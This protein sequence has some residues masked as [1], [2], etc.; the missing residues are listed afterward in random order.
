MGKL[1][2]LLKPVP[3]TLIGYIWDALDNDDVE[4]VQGLQRG[5]NWFTLIT[6]K[7][8]LRLPFRIPLVLYSPWFHYKTLLALSKLSSED[9]VLI[10][11]QKNKY[12]CKI[13]RRIVPKGVRIYNYF[14]NPINRVFS[15]DIAKQSIAEIA[16]MGFIMCSFDKNDAELYNMKY[17]GQYLRHPE[18]SQLETKTDIDFFFCGLAKD[19]KGFL[20]ELL[21]KLVRSGFK[22]CF[23]VPE[24]SRDSITG[25]Q[26][27]EYAFRSRCIVDICQKGQ[28][29]LTR[30]PLEAL[31][32]RKK[33]LTNNSY[34]SKTG[35]IEVIHWHK[36]KSL[37]PV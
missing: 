30:R 4:N 33:L 24:N 13:I 19:R 20:D 2:V 36:E 25:D 1:L 35:M 37:L 26:Y 3:K 27:C 10:L 16:D 18:R 31:F 11:E 17:V 9:N 22:C 34:I 5:I 21:D 12:V 28:T 15:Q 14:V 7:P 32:F 8:I 6:R 23:I 29:G